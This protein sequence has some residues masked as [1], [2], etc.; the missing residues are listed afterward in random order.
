MAQS[1]KRIEPDRESQDSSDQGNC[2]LATLEVNNLS[3]RC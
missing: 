1:T 3:N 2:G